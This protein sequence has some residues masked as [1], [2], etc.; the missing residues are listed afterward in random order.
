MVMKSLTDHNQVKVPEPS[1]R[2]E[3]RVVVRGSKVCPPRKSRKSRV[4]RVGRRKVKEVSLSN[5]RLR[6]NKR[7]KEL[8]VKMNDHTFQVIQFL[9]L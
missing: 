6:I 2:K 4:F 3:T 5:S 1:V 7:R 8:K 9:K